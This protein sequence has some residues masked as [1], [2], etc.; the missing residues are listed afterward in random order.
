MA[1]KRIP[2]NQSMFT[3]N[4]VAHSAPLGCCIT[5][6]YSA[7]V[8]G[9]PRKR[10]KWEKSHMGLSNAVFYIDLRVGDINRS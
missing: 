10:K 7:I 5:P 6:G 3:A 1:G 4:K 8:F 2:R 9:N